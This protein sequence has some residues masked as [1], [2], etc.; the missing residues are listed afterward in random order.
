MQTR[1]GW[2]AEDIQTARDRAKE[3]ANNGNGFGLGLGAAASSWATPKGT[4]FSR[5]AMALWQ[6]P[7]SDDCVN[8]EKGKI[9]SRGEPKLS[10]EAILWS[11]PRVTTGQYTRDQ[12]QKG[13]ERLTL[14]GE[15]AQ[16]WA[17]P[18]AHN[19]QGLPGSGHSERQGRPADLVR[20][21]TTWPTPASQNHKGSSADSVTR[22][23]GKSRMDILHYRAEQGFSLPAPE[24]VTHGGSPYSA[25]DTWRRLYRYV[26]R[27]HGR[28]TARRLAASGTPRLNPLFVEWLMHWPSGHALCACSETEWSRYVLASRGALS[29]LP[30]ASCQWIWKPPAEMNTPEQG[31]LF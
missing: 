20:D 12:G 31:E 2:S 15:A 30:T 5:K 23:D 16:M 27:T 29:R 25:R 4:D 3:K 10:A 9:N 24:T 21:A 28:A 11:T 6:T 7:V 18:N 26:R 14:E 13:R 8:R 1:D 19:A 17:T 22:Q